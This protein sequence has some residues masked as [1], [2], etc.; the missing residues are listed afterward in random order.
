MFRVHLDLTI[1]GRPGQE[2]TLSLEREA[3]GIPNL[4]ESPVPNQ[5]PATEGFRMI[6]LIG[7]DLLQFAVLTYRGG[8]GVYQLEFNLGAIPRR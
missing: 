7:R 2:T 3:I 4:H 6:G 1:Q 8:E 5:T